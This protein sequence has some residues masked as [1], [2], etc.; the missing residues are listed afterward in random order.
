MKKT[1]GLKKRL[2]AVASFIPKGAR[3]TD[4]GTDH[5]YL[6]VYLVESGIC[7]RIIATDI[8]AGPLVSAR[9]NINGH[10]LG[11]K[12]ELRQGDGLEVLKPGEVDVITITGLGGSTIVKMLEESPGVLDEVKRLILQPMGD[13]GPLRI[14]LTTHGWR[15]VDEKLVKEGGKLYVIV[16]AEPG[17]EEIK[18]PLLLEIGPLLV[19]KRDPLL[20]VYLA[21]LEGKYL[22]IL[23]GLA[24]SRRRSIASKAEFYE[25]RLSKVREVISWL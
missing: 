25:K 18:D 3:V 15:I 13:E 1:K 7:S 16:V 19:E 6:P 14:W 10:N 22:D 11:K 20:K 2:A 9:R 8:S 4:I 21:E 24:K 17:R 12:I 5:A 23:E